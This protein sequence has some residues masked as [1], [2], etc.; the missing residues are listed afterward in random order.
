MSKIK[1]DKDRE[2]RIDMEVVVD[3]YDS[4]ERA[5]GWYYYNS[6]ATTH[7]V[8][9]KA[10]NDWGLYDMHGNVREWC[11]DWYDIF[12]PASVTDPTGPVVG[13]LRVERGGGCR[14][15]AEMCRS[16]TRGND[17]PYYKRI[18]LGFRLVREP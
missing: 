12:L 13:T 1:K 16:A 14:D 18:V 6:D 17:P 15:R 3:A 4:E 9:Q 5:M 2:Y 8:A 10:A 11:Q 7:P